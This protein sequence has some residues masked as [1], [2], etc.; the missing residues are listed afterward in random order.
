MNHPLT[1]ALSLLWKLLTVL[2]LPIIIA[3]YVKVMDV[4]YGPFSFS[5]LDLGQNLHKWL[6]FAIYLLFLLCWNRLNAHVINA[7]KKMEY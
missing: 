6:I 3:V 1:Q 2:I 4:Y 7:L 5:E